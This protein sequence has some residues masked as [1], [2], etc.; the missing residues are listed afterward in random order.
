VDKEIN[1][2]YGKKAIKSLFG[3]NVMS[4]P[5][6]PYL[7]KKLAEIGSGKSDIVLDFFGGSGTLAQSVIELN[8]EDGGN[9][10]FIIVQLPETLDESSTAYKLGYKSI[11]DIAEAR[12]KKVIEVVQ[13]DNDS[14]LSFKAPQNL[15]F[16]KYT[17]ASSNFKIWRGDVVENETEL[18]KQME[19]FVTPQ[20]AN[21]ESENIL[22]E[23][24]IK[25]G[26]LLTEK[27]Q[28]VEAGEGA[29]IYQTSDKRFAFVLDKFTTEVQ[30][31]VFALKP[32]TVICL[33][34]LFQNQDMVK[35]NAQ[36][37]FEDN[38][39]TFKTV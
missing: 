2:D 37:K 14:K 27:I 9:R 39:I 12:I 25:N 23:L 35:T 34:S 18:T 38:D 33:D 6:S 5:K 19:L 24:L 32:R 36:L 20:R 4:F 13:E 7:C 11:S 30:E 31:K 28:Q 26:V 15:G 8:N 3:V 22:W 17:L 29:R 21:A 1:N 10:K 16:R